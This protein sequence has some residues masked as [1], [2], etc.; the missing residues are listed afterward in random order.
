VASDDAKGAKGIDGLLDLME[1]AI[2]AILLQNDNEDLDGDLLERLQG[3]P[4]KIAPLRTSVRSIDHGKPF[5][6]DLTPRDE[7]LITTEDQES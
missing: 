2:A 4:D 1:D 6:D 3:A 5:A 7:A